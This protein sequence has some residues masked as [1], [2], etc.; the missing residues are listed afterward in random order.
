MHWSTRNLPST[1]RIIS[2]DFF[3]VYGEFALKKG[4]VRRVCAYTFMSSWCCR[5]QLLSS[6]LLNRKK[7]NPAYFLICYR[8]INGVKISFYILMLS[9]L[10]LSSWSCLGLENTLQHRNVGFA[11]HFIFSICIYLLFLA[12]ELFCQIKVDT[13]TSGK[14][15]F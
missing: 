13:I 8:I 6:C 10:L 14:E 4:Y 2:L 9:S 7:K 5:V 15:G 1:P 11:A 3:P 12:T